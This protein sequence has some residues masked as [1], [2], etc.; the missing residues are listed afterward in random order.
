[1]SS[2]SFPLRKGPSGP[3]LNASSL[4]PFLDLANSIKL[5]AASGDP[6][7]AF[8]LVGPGTFWLGPIS[9]PP[10]APAVKADASAWV[11]PVDCRIYRVAL[12]YDAGG[13]G[14][15]NVTWDCFINDVA[16]PGVLVG[17]DPTVF[18]PYTFPDLAL[19]DG[20]VGMG[21]QITA[22]VTLLAGQQL[23]N[24][25]FWAFPRML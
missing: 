24:P 19:A 9:S 14:P 23:V 2:A 4:D 1:M 8:V 10:Y 21:Q 22:N 20:G 3:R 15:G 17:T 16:I 13:V 12:S 11:A 7:N 25:S 6:A 18:G 5:G